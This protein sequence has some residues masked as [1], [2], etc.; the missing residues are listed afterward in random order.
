MILVLGGDVVETLA[1]QI[2]NP[3]YVIQAEQ[4]VLAQRLPDVALVQF[5][6]ADDRHKAARFARAKVMLHISLRQGGE[7]GC[8]RAETDRSGGKV[9]RVGVFG[10]AG[11]GLQSSEAAQFFETFHR[12]VSQ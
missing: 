4:L 10:P 12:Q 7:D 1:I 2:N 6:I 8:S 9:N 3:E 5:R 11:I